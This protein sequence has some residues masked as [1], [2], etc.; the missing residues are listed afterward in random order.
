MKSEL[1]ASRSRP[2]ILKKAAAGLVLVAVAALAI[3]FRLGLVRG[4]VLDRR[5]GR[6][7]RR[8]ALGGQ[9]PPLTESDAGSRPARDP[10]LLRPGRRDRRDG[11]RELVLHLVS[12][13]VLRA[14]H[15]PARPRSSTATTPRSCVASARSAARSLKLHDAVC[16]RC[17]DRARVPRRGDRFA[18]RPHAPAGQPDFRAV[19]LGR[20]THGRASKS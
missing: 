17:G 10:V 11:S 9:H 1:E 20:S 6:R 12:G 7:D 14:V 5:R 2:P 8:R 3:P 4:G 15:R 19:R 13:L 18:R 16:M